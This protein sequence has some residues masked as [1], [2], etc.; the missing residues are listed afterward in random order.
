LQLS[1]LGKGTA[2]VTEIVVKGKEGL[3]LPSSFEVDTVNV[4]QPS[5]RESKLFGVACDFF[6]EDTYLWCRDRVMV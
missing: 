2:M 5:T 1:H 3:K 4:E 6:D